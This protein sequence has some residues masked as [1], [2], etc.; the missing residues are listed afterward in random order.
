[1]ALLAPLD[2]RLLDLIALQVD[3]QLTDAVQAGQLT[4]DQAAPDRAAI[5][6]A[7]LDL[8]AGRPFN[9][10]AASPGIAQLLRSLQANR[11]Q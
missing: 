1:M 5:A 8:R 6:Q 10:S 9:S 4:E 2:E 7:V 11:M 3:Q